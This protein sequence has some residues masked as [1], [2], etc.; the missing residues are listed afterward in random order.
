MHE[1]ASTLSIYVRATHETAAA[2]VLRVHEL[3]PQVERCA[4][5]YTI[6]IVRCKRLQNYATVS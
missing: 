3:T 5:V 6:T 1:L 4:F 2:G